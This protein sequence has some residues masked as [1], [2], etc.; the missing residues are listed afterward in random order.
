MQ[1]ERLKIS[2][3]ANKYDLVDNAKIN[4]FTLLSVADPNRFQNLHHKGHANEVDINDKKDRLLEY[5]R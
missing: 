3:L 4:G 1:E 2:N 5:H